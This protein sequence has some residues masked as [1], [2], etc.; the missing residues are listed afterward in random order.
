[1][2]IG[3]KTKFPKELGKKPTEFVKKIQDGI[4]ITT[5][6]EDRLKRW[7]AGRVIQFYEGGYRQGQRKKFHEDTCKSVQEVVM[8]NAFGEILFSFDGGKQK[9]LSYEQ[10]FDMARNDGFDS[11]TEFITYFI[12]KAGSEWKGR[13][14]HWTD[15]K[16]A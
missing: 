6:R 2:I 8:Q 12:P 5:F 14:I 16:Y 15:L 7:K 10:L 11:V 1:M 9:S 4:K 13:I 3:F